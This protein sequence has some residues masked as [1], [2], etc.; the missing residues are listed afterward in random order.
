M[1]YFF[2]LFLWCYFNNFILVKHFVT[3]ICETFFISCFFC[4]LFFLLVSSLLSPSLHFLLFTSLFKVVLLFSYSSL[5]FL[6]IPF[7]IYFDFYSLFRPLPLFCYFFTFSFPLSFLALTFSQF[8]V[9]LF[10]S[11]RFLSC[12]LTGLSS[13]PQSHVYGD[14][15]R[16]EDEQ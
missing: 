1:F 4:E 9:N 6:S 11:F 2:L 3:F 14:A 12:R 10:F 15:R 7:F 8:N 13:P 16:S 5:H